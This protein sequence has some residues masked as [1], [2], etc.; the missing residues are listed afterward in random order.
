MKKIVNE[1]FL[2]A[3]GIFIVALSIH[4][5]M[6]PNNFVIGGISGLAIVINS[7]MPTLEVGLIMIILDIILFAL[8][9]ITIGA[10]FGGRTLYSSFLLSGSVWFLN[11]FFPITEP[12]V[13]D[14]FIQ[15]IL[16]IVL[17]AIG[18]AVVFRHN[19]S[20]GGTDITAKILNKFFHIDLGKGVLLSDLVVTLLAFVTFDLDTVFYGIVGIF[21]NGLIIDFILNKFK[22]SKEV[23]II[24][25]DLSII[26]PFIMDE[27]ERSATIY[28]GYGAYTNEERAII[29]TILNRHE[30]IRLKKF[31]G[32]SKIE[33]FITVSNINEAFGLGFESLTE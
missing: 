3:L 25:H 6:I 30:Y 14:R 32:D 28:K 20:T 11:L 17:S 8:G 9:F 19:A 18:M 23:R 7:L 2:I 16:C 29:T 22:E 5:F 27:L 33:A 15:L 12:L 13:E 31:I 1:Y 10:H 24:T 4:L 21:L 26:K